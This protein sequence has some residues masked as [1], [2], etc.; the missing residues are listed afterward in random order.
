MRHV[1]TTYY[2]PAQS[3][4]RCTKCNTASV[5]TL[6]YSTWQY[7]CRRC[8]IMASRS[9]WWTIEIRKYTDGKNRPIFWYRV[10]G[11]AQK[12]AARSSDGAVRAAQ[13][14]RERD[15]AF[16]V[17]SS[18]VVRHLFLA[19]GELARRFHQ[20]QSVW[21][22]VREVADRRRRQRHMNHLLPPWPQ[23]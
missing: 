13:R 12:K 11:N 18:V 5:S 9:L 21:L 2:S 20:P 7:N 23:T 19:D 6:Y 16:R 3:P 1:Y 8:T 22:R 4:P 17:T 14:Q 10:S 15:G